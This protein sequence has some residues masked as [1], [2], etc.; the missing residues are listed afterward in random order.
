M[1]DTSGLIL[2]TGSNGRIGSAIMPRLTGKYVK[3]RAGQVQ[4]TI[5]RYPD[6]GFCCFSRAPLSVRWTAGRSSDL[7]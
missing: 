7:T 5:R 1:N 4:E 6:F 3:V 2:V